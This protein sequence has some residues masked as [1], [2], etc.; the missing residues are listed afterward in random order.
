MKMNEG[1]HQSMRRA[2]LLKVLQAVRQNGPLS[3]P[4][5]QRISE[6]SWG[7]VM[8]CCEEL[9]KREILTT[10]GQ[11]ISG[12]V[13]RRSTMFDF[14]TRSH[15]VLGIDLGSVNTRLVL[16]D[17]RGNVLRKTVLATPSNNDGKFIVNE[18]CCFADQWLSDLPGE[19][20]RL[21]GVSF[22]V[23][24]SVDVET[25]ICLLAPH[26]VA[27]K[28]LPLK[29]QVEQFFGQPCVVE[30]S[31]TCLAN[32]EKWFGAGRSAQN[33]LC[34]SMGAGLG[35]GIIVNG[36]PYRGS[37]HNAGQIGHIPV[38]PGGRLCAC[39][40]K[41]CLEAYAS[42]SAIGDIAREQL[43]RTKPGDSGV[44]ALAR[45]MEDITGEIVTQAAANGDKAA[46]LLLEE[47]GY[48]LGLGLT[49][50]V[51]LFNPE[52][53]TFSGGFSHAFEFFRP[54]LEETLKQCAWPP[55][56]CPIEVS[57]LG[58]EG[59]ALGAATLVLDR[60]YEGQLLV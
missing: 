60:V 29:A 6:L 49:A 22:A 1:S 26:F 4:E 13:G 56:V 5:I 17:L 47:V 52:R 24:G 20:S 25:G 34:L 42:A 33:L 54:K 14:S 40:R 23:P 12:R 36:R 3:R 8:N 21:A 50:S 53:I 16:T 46:M 19:S 18:V 37:K 31:L 41:G 35:L 57:K 30:H 7:S 27:L 44:L 32:A 10:T 38:V 2:N 45:R 15:L 48:Y 55:C 43:R 51:N 28:N 59:V 58:D 39:G 9:C 11:S